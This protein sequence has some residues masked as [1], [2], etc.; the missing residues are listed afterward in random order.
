MRRRV[1]GCSIIA[2]LL[3]A[4]PVA[5]QVSLMHNATPAAVTEALKATFVPQ[6]FQVGK[7]DDKG[8]LFTLDKG[9]MT[10]NTST[11]MQVFHMVVEIQARYK[12]KSEGLE[13]SLK[14]EVVAT[15]NTQEVRNPVQTRTELDNLQ[16]LLDGVRTD[17]EAKA[18][19]DSSGH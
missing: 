5:G 14:E 8:A 4:G 2:S 19:R 1:V 3:A 15:T 17:L 18:K 10:Q 13:V 7:A 12:H 6:G 9:D 11:G 16:T